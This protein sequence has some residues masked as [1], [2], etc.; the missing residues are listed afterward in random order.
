MLKKFSAK[1]VLIAGFSVALFSFGFNANANFDVQSSV[2]N[3]KFMVP[4]YGVIVEDDTAK[5]GGCGMGTMIIDSSAC[6]PEQNDSGDK[7]CLIYSC[8]VSGGPNL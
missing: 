1:S 4:I 5:N 6:T 7:S 8:R 3:H 2:D